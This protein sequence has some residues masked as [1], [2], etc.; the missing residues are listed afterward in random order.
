MKRPVRPWICGALVLASCLASSARGQC[1]YE[2]VQVIK[3][4]QCGILESPTIPTA[5]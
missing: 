2:V 5:P 4:P 1:F 3:V